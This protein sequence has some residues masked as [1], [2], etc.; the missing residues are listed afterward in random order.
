ME[1]LVAGCIEANLCD[2]DFDLH[3]LHLVGEDVA[4]HL[5]VA[6]CQAARIDV[7]SGVLEAL[8]VS[9]AHASDTKL[10][11]LVVLADASERDA[12]INL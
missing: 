10:V 8:E 6:V 5:G 4:E 2:E 9:G 12:I 3:R 11:E 1:H 7:V